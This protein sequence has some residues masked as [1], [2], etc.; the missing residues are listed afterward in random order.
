MTTAIATP[1]PARNTDQSPLPLSRPEITAVDS[2]KS[3]TYYMIQTLSQNYSFLLPDKNVGFLAS[4][5]DMESVDTIP[6][7]VFNDQYYPIYSFSS[8]LTPSLG[9][10]RGDNK[11]LLI[12]TTN[13]LRLGLSCR[14]IYKIRSHKPVKSLPGFMCQH[15]PF[16]A[17]LKYKESWLY[18]TT[19]DAIFE[20]LESQQTSSPK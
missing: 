12:E 3:T 6:C 15:S 7:L 16:K 2:E 14:T 10:A 5:E 19:A 8:G 4:T 20:Y 1:H 18:L 13:G 9:L 17:V 11:A